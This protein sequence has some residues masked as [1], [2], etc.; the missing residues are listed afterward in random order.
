MVSPIH[1]S[2]VQ[3]KYGEENKTK[4]ETEM[5]EVCCVQERWEWQVQESCVSGQPGFLQ[6]TPEGNQ[7]IRKQCY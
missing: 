7:S 2:K 6:V 3:S 5:Q 4:E 1:F